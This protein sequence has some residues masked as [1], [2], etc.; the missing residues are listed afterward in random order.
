MDSDNAVMERTSYRGPDGV[1]QFIEDMKGDWDV[2]ES[3]AEEFCDLGDDRVLVLGTWRARG[4]GSGVELDFQKAAWLMH[5]RDGKVVR[6]QT[7]TDREKAFEA[8]GIRE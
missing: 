3:R 6:M 7:F 2:F 1:R 8:A 4:R 5:F